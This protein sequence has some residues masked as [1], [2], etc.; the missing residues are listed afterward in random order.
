L[1]VSKRE[2]Y[3]SDQDQESEIR[4]LAG[5][6]K[7]AM[8]TLRLASPNSKADLS[9]LTYLAGDTRRSFSSSRPLMLVEFPAMLY[10]SFEGILRCLQSLHINPANIPL[11]TWLAP[12]THDTVSTQEPTAYRSDRGTFVPPPAYLQNATLNLSCIP[13]TTDNDNN[14]VT[15]PLTMSLSQDPQMLSTRLSEITTLDTGQATAMIS[16][17]RHEIA[18]IQGP[19]GTGKS[20]VGI[21][22]ARVLLENRDVLG[23]G[24]ILCV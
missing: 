20:Y 12:R 14:G 18:L 4:D 1:Q 21:Q 3:A 9:N 13:T 6:A 10:N 23:L 19:P 7:R 22:I 8:I 17:L 5:D 15:T 24:P 2:I 16:A 11:T